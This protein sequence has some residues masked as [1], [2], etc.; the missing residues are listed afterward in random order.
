MAGR[1]RRLCAAVAFWG[2]G[3]EDLVAR[4]GAG[5]EPA[6]ILCNLQSGACNP[7]VIE[8]LRDKWKDWA[9][10]KRQAIVQTV[11]VN[12]EEYRCLALLGAAA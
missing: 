3:A 1:L 8:K 10:S 5:S 9:P 7:Y 4:R 11:I 6:Q 12:N 2:Q